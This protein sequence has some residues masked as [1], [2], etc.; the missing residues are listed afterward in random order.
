MSSKH[1]LYKPGLQEGPTE[2]ELNPL[3]SE[4]VLW[5]DAEILDRRPEFVKLNISTRYRA[6]I[7][8]R[9]ARQSG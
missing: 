4:I 1:S 6:T 3:I 5:N 9:T 8:M 2:F 7:W